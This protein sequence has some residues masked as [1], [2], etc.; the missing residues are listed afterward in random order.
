MQCSAGKV[1]A[2]IFEIVYCEIFIDHLEKKNSITGEHYVTLVHELNKDIKKILPDLRRKFGS[3]MT[4]HRPGST[5]RATVKIVSLGNKLL[6]QCP[7][8]MGLGP[9][10]CYLF[11]I[12]LK[13]WFKRKRFHSNKEAYRQ[14]KPFFADYHKSHYTMGVNWKKVDGQKKYRL[15][16][17]VL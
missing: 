9:T 6:S 13:I 1:L 3:I 15:G 12:N 17:Q 8:S 2:S 14:R 10:S 4:T 11:S 5:I 7:H 16:V